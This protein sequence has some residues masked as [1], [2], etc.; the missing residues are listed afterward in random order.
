MI[1]LNYTAPPYPEITGER[2]L[3]DGRKVLWT[4]KVAI[5]LLHRPLPVMGSEAERIQEIL[6]RPDL[7]PLPLVQLYVMTRPRYDVRRPAEGIPIWALLLAG[8]LLLEW[9]WPR[10]R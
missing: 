9:F 6:L 8:L 4:G 7:P 1:S 2:V 5:G 10:R 3:G